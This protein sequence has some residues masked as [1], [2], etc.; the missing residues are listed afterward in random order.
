MFFTF[1]LIIFVL[2]CVSG[3]E[4]AEKAKAQREA[5]ATAIE[6]AK[7]QQLGIEEYLKQEN[8]EINF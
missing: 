7:L 1:I 8:T 3:A 5:K 4:D 2:I 6:M